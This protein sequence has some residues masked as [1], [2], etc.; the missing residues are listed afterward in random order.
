MESFDEKVK[1]AYTGAKTGR[2]QKI[3]HNL[4]IIRRSM[5]YMSCNADADEEYRI[6]TND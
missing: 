2:E 1:N 3:N 4:Y 6:S 5:Y